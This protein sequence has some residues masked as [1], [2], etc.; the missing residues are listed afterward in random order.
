MNPGSVHID[1]EGAGMQKSMSA[2][3]DKVTRLL[4]E[5][6]ARRTFRTRMHRKHGVAVSDEGRRTVLRTRFGYKARIRTPI[7][8]ID[9]ELGDRSYVEA[10]CR[11]AS[12]KIGKFTAIAPGCHIGLAEHPS[13]RAVSSHPI[14]YRRDPARGFD[15]VEQN[16]HE[17]VRTTTVG[18]DVW[19]GVNVIVK[20]GMTIGDG[21]I[22]GAGAVVTDDIPA[23]AVAVGVPARVIRYRFEPHE[24]SWLLETRWWDWDE[25]TLR[26]HSRDFQDLDTLLSTVD[27]GQGTSSVLRD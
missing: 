17:E 7:F 27:P 15:F 2:L 9:S 23:Y 16:L 1:L 14:F 6:L 13:R 10:H 12:A 25:R 18:N 8:L 26:Q 24:I 19:I 4:P 3:A 21:A 22:V 11:I 20:G 5:V